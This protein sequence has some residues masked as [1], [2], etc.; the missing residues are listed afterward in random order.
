MAQIKALD[1][2]AEDRDPRMPAQAAERIDSE[3]AL[4]MKLDLFRLRAFFFAG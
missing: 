2:L 4:V 3:A 1:E